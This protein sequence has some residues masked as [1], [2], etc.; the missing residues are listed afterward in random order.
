MPQDGVRKYAKLQLL[1]RFRM[2]AVFS[3]FR[4][5]KLSTLQSARNFTFSRKLSSHSLRAMRSADGA[6]KPPGDHYLV[7]AYRFQRARIAIKIRY[8]ITRYFARTKGGYIFC[9]LPPAP[10][11]SRWL[12]SLNKGSFF[13]NQCC[14][15]QCF[16][17][18]LWVSGQICMVSTMI[19]VDV[20]VCY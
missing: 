20:F 14:F 5:L 2:C 7:K 1:G 13:I 15:R 17:N 3:C 10:I 16:T 11:P 12:I 8:S 18:C 19:K 6:W 9:F 4:Q